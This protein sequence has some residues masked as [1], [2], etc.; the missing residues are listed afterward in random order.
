MPSSASGGTCRS[1][2]RRST[3]CTPSRRRGRRSPVSRR[4]TATNRSSRLAIAA[5]RFERLHV[6]AHHR[7]GRRP[8]TRRRAAPETV[9]RWATQS[10]ARPQARHRPVPGLHT[11]CQTPSRSWPRRR[12]PLSN[13]RRNARATRGNASRQMASVSGL[14]FTDTYG[15][16]SC[17]RASIP[18][19]A[20]SVGGRAAS[21]R[22]RRP[23]ARAASTGFAGSP[24]G[25]CPA[26]SGPRSASTSAPVP[27]VVGTAM[28]GRDRAA[29]ACPRPTTSR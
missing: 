26:R 19:D 28:N 6:C 17:V 23:P 20:V 7:C 10:R 18:V 1:S 14:A 13:A 3:H 15:S 21:V 27:A 29:M 5:A 9:R 8:R 25:G 24:S 4:A 11:S 22:D 2:R 16:I 12:R